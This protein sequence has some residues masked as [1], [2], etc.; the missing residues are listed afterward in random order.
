MWDCTCPS[1]LAAANVQ[2]RAKPDNDNNNKGEPHGAR[3]NQS[4]QLI[5]CNSTRFSCS[6]LI[7]PPFTC[8]NVKEQLG[9]RWWL[10]MLFKR[11]TIH[12]QWRPQHGKQT[13]LNLA[14]WIWKEWT[15]EEK[16]WSSCKCIQEIKVSSSNGNAQQHRRWKWFHQMVSSRKRCILRLTENTVVFFS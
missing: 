8:N 3:Q 13:L 5:S 2:M 16:Q 11:L 7:K 12:P 4:G 15:K 9:Q 6:L 1:S 14:R 10:M